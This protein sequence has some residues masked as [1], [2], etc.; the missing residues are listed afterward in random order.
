MTDTV[1]GAHNDNVNQVFTE[2]GVIG[3]LGTADIR[4]T[5]ETL[6]M[7]VDPATGA[8]YV[9]N[10]GPAG[11]VSLGDIT[12]GTI[13]RIGS[14]DTI[15]T[16]TVAS[17]S[18]QNIVTGTQQTL[19][20]V[21]TILGIG[22]TVQVAGASAGTNVNVITGSLVAWDNLAKFAF[23]NIVASYPDGTTENYIYKAGT[24]TVGTVVVVYT[25]STKGSVST[26][27]R[28]L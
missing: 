1:H 25:D 20:T 28:S 23:D 13:D 14:I 12:G 2:I 5:A 16:V 27:T 10:L 6:P 17:G 8:Q 19:G 15:G 21:G 4:G 11:S 18:Y 9:Y 7:S 24:S 3:T 22:G 26:V